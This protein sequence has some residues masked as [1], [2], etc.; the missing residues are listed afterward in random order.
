MLTARE[1]ARAH[2][3]SLAA[4]YRGDLA[5]TL[6]FVDWLAQ[7]WAAAGPPEPEGAPD[8]VSGGEAGCVVRWY[9]RGEAILG[10]EA[11][12]SRAARGCWRVP[13]DAA[14]PVSIADPPVRNSA[15]PQP[16]GWGLRG[17]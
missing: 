17:R 14:L 7:H 12:R 6:G 13:V 4:L 8:A 10:Y 1:L 9:E 2:D 15:R 11:R 3:R 5:E 16:W